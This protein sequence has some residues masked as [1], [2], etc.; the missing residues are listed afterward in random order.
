MSCSAASR[1]FP[2]LPLQITCYSRAS[3]SCLTK[4]GPY[5][6]RHRCGGDAPPY[7]RLLALHGALLR[8]ENTKGSN[9]LTPRLPLFKDPDSW[10]LKRCDP[11]QAPFRLQPQ[12]LRN[13]PI[14]K[15]LHRRPRR[16]PHLWSGV[17]G[18]A[19]G[20]AGGLEALKFVP[21][22]VEP[23]LYPCFVAG[24]FGEG[25]RCVCIPDKGSA[26]RGGLRTMLLSLHLFSLGE[27]LLVLLLV[28]YPG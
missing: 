27:G 1:S 18:R 4:T 22:L 7:R 11:L 21:G 6:S 26:E 20:A 23:A 10:P 28:R 25:V 17:A 15:V 16:H 5:C 13:E 9:T 2:L 24:E 8:E 14:F 12:F 19:L 3:W